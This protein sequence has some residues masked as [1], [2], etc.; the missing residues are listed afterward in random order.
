MDPFIK[1]GLKIIAY[2]VY[3]V[4]AFCLLLLTYLIAVSDMDKGDLLTWGGQA[5]LLLILDHVLL[6]LIFVSIT[7]FVR[8]VKKKIM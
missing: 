1:R 6:S 5:L 2:I 8:W 7:M 3:G 4:G